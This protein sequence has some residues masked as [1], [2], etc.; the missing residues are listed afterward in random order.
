M[1]ANYSLA[2]SNITNASITARWPDDHGAGQ[3]Q[4]LRRRHHLS[5][6]CA[7]DE[8][9]DP[10]RRHGSTWTQT[11]DNKNVGTNKTLTPDSLKVTDGNSGNNYIYT[12]TP[13]STGTITPKP[14]AITAPTVTKVYD[15]GT[16]AGTV[17][18]GT[19]SG[20]VGTETVTATG[21]ATAYSSRNVGSA[22]AATVSYTLANG[23]NGGLATNYSLANS[24]IANAAITARPLTITA[25]TNTKFY[26]GDTSSLTNA[27][28]TRARSS[29]G[30]RRLPGPRRMILLPLGLA[31]RSPPVLWWSLTGIVASTTA[32]RILQ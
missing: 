2:N 19:L 18:V 26:D 28:L 5:H 15:G 27:L 24:V 16:T 30:T 12:Y 6:E 25:Q 4:D 3:L 13:V 8:R 22:Y 10:N 31:R 21:T 1:A 14:L 32:T 20:F 23:L 9:H 11:Y 17:T 29:L 7:T